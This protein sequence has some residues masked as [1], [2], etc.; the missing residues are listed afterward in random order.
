MIPWLFMVEAIVLVAV[1]SIIGSGLNTL[2]GYLHSK[3]PYSV[4]KLAG[5]VIIATFTALALSQ[6]IVVDGLTEAGVVL[7]GLVTGFAA[8]YAVTK[9]KTD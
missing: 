9:A 6:H 8:D 4:K 2:R 3:D 1:A 7:V 5:S